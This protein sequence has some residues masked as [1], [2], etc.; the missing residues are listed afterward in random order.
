MDK[1]KRII[2]VELSEK[3]FPMIAVLT[4]FIAIFEISH[5]FTNLTSNYKEILLGTIA[6]IMGIVI[7]FFILKSINRKREGTVF[8]SYSHKDKKFIEKLVQSLKT[9]RF[10]VIYDEDIVRVG[11]NIKETILH[12]IDKSDVIILVL[13]ESIETE[14]YLDYELKY[15]R[16]KN[17]KILPIIIDNKVQIPGEISN[18]KYADFSKEYENNLR[19]L[20]KSLIKSLEKQNKS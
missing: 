9:R 12:S 2:I 11:D 7:S 5:E 4:S 16:E 20:I 3:V 6:S 17:K 14:N 15:A 10:N 19:L 1:K 13:S 18:I 8:I